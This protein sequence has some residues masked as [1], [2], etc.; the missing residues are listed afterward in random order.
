MRI[1]S[2]MASVLQGL[3]TTTAEEIGESCG[4]IQR[5]REF[6]AS[7]LVSTFVLGFLQRPKP[8]WEQLAL[9]ARQLGA[10]VTPQAVLL[11][12]TPQLRDTLRQ[13]WEA[14]VQCVVVS[15]S[16]VTPLLRKFSE[17]L[18]GDSTTIGLNEA[19]AAEF[20]GCGGA[21]NYGR[22]ALKLQVVWDYLSGQFRRLTCEAGKQND[23]TSL[24]QGPCP[25][26]GSL[27]IFDLGYFSL[28]R[29]LRWQQAGVHWISRGISD[30]VVWIDE[31]PHD[32]HN[33]LETQ[34]R[35]PIDQLV[36]VGTAKLPCRLLAMRVPP[37]VSGRRR[38]KA[39]E[40]AAKKGR[41]PTARHLATCEWT[42]FLTSCS[43]EL[44]T[45]QEVVVLYRVRWQIELLFKLWKSHGLIDAHRSDDPVRQMVE[46][47]ARLTAVLI[48]H[49]LIL[50]TC[51]PDERLSLTRISRLVRD[52]VPQLIA[53]LPRKYDLVQTLKSW[54]R[55]LPG[56]GRIPSNRA[57]P[58][59]FELLADPQRLTYTS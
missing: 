53:T 15:E 22:A 58:G 16:R 26:R 40:K 27:S 18:I 14:A 46:F 56:L 20:P 47:Y 19:L 11:R 59:N 39:Y 3:L 33:W 43:S 2:R 44:L 45:W 49:W 17:I 8:T 29:F 9:T 51:W 41:R 24:D 28:E 7:S 34:P 50:V 37:E 36:K 13:V 21:H 31:Q 10:H 52:Q 54:T 55:S 12:V 4:L 25:R 57:K 23:S 30:L 48:Q 6:T 32:L 38:Q 35:G 1:L 42:V 5:Q